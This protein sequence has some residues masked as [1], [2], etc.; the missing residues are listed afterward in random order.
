MRTFDQATCALFTFVDAPQC[1]GH[2]VLGDVP[3]LRPISLRE[4]GPAS[5]IDICM[6]AD[7]SLSSINIVWST[8]DE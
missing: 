8:V 6:D 4:T 3:A 7:Q 1:I 5:G 2:F